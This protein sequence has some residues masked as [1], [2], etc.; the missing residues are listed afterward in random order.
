MQIISIENKLHFWGL[1]GHNNVRFIA[2][3]SQ[4]LDWHEK[5]ENY[6]IAKA[7]RQ[8][9]IP[10]ETQSTGCILTNSTN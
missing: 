5:K 7:S 3:G 8:Y 9:N 10:A 2:Y 1:D 4:W 6:Q